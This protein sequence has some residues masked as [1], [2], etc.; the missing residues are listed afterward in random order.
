MSLAPAVRADAGFWWTRDDLGF[1]DG[2]LHLAG[3]DV[4]ALAETVEGPLYVYSAARIAA[5]LGRVREALGRTGRPSRVYYA[6]K[7]NRFE[8]VLRHLAR[9]GQCG[10]DICSPNELDRALACGFAAADISFTGTGVANRDLDRLLAHPDLTLNCDSI[11]MIR[12]IG[13]RAPGRAIGVRVN[14]ERGTGY[15]GAEKLT[16][17]G[18]VATKFGI[19]REQWPQALATARAHGLTITSLHFHVGCGYLTREL[20]AWEAAVDAGL[21]FLDDLPDVATVNVGGGLGLPHGEADAALDLDR[22]AAVLARRFAGREVTIACEPGDYIV[23]DAGV[24]VLGVTDVER[25]RDVTFVHVDGGFNLAP[26]PA[27][28]DLPCEPVACAPRGFDTAAWSPVT[29]AGNINEALDIWA[30]GKPM[31]ELREGDRIAFLNAG[32][33]GASMSSNHCM[34]GDFTEILLPA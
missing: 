27:Y 31:P 1:I 26:E 4:G 9:T 13:E 16:Y 19:Y 8:P 34:R 6:M 28:Y 12:R 18:D 11:G 33:Y 22:W 10:V 32:G 3:Q 14:P 24:L 17:A 30:H 23:K 29:L 25:K 20:D 2:R 15:A 21:A 5:N 7:A